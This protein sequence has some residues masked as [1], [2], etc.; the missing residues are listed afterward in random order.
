MFPGHNNRGMNNKET[1]WMTT[2]PHGLSIFHAQNE[3]GNLGPNFIIN[4]QI[5]AEFIDKIC[6]N[7]STQGYRLTVLLYQ[8]ICTIECK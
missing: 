6:M 8:G 2:R 1:S 5:Y 7:S 4:A 3:L